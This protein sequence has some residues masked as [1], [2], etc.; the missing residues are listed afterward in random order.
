MSHL[1]PALLVLLAAVPADAGRSRVGPVVRE[2][3]KKR[4]ECRAVTATVYKDGAVAS[5][6]DPEKTSVKTCNQFGGREYDDAMCFI[7]K[8]RLPNGEEGALGF[9]CIELIDANVKHFDAN[10]L[11]LYRREYDETIELDFKSGAGRISYDRTLCDWGR[12]TTVAGEAELVECR[13][14]PEP[15]KDCADLPG[16]E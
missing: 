12:C 13:I 16:D 14:L 5:T 2:L 9:G 8:T 7:V 10:S 6:L 4:F 1:L 11:R 3:V 15:S